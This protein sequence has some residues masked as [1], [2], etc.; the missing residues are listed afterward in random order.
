MSRR[1]VN[2]RK[3]EPGRCTVCGQAVVKPSQPIAE[4]TDGWHG[5]KPEREW[6]T[7]TEGGHFVLCG[8]LYDIRCA[9][10]LPVGM[11]AHGCDWPAQTIP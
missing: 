11:R 3:I 9:R 6:R 4:L 10:C 2:G 1:R 7:S 8:E 5:D